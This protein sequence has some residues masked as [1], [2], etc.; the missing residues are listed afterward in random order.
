MAIVAIGPARNVCRV[1]AGSRNPIMA[2]RAR[3]QHLGVI[4]CN[5]RFERKRV[6]AVF[7]HIGGLNVHR[8]LASCG[9]PVVTANAVADNSGMVKYRGQPAAGAMTIVTLIA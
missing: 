7:A 9:R 8:A 6:V 2:R 1:L 5:D 4:H 3:A